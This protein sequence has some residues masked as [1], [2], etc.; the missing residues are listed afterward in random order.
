MLRALAGVLL[1]SSAFGLSVASAQL[2]VAMRVNSTDV[3]VDEPFQLQITVES[4]SLQNPDVTL[5]SL[6][7]FNVLQ[8]QVS[9]PM[10]FSFSFGGRQQA[11]RSTTNYIFVLQ[12]TREGRFT[13]P[14]VEA[15]V[16]KE[17]FRSN[18][19]TITV[20]GSTA[21]PGSPLGT[22][23]PPADPSQAAPPTSTTPPKGPIADT[24]EIDDIA[25]IRAVAD[26]PNPYVGEQVT[27][28]FY[29]YLRGNVQAAPSVDTQPTTDGFWIHDLL[30]PNA[31]QQGHR[32]VVRGLSYTAFTLRRFAAFPLR[33]GPLSIGPMAVTIDQSSVFD[34]FAGRPPPVL[35]RSGQPLVIEA[36]PLPEAGKPKGEV[37]VGRFTIEAKLDRNQAATG[38]AV[39]LSATV[40]GTGNIRTV[41]LATPVVDGLRFLEPAVRDVVEAPGDLAGG[42]RTYEWLV[43]PERPGTFTLPPIVLPVFDPGA[44][45]YGAA[46]SEALTLVAAGS[47]VAPQ[48]T[49]NPAD[50]TSDTVAAPD[51]PQEDLAPIRTTSELRRR[52]SPLV[53]SLAYRVGIAA[54]ALVWL[55]VVFGA[56]ASRRWSARRNAPDADRSFREAG[57]KLEAAS[58]EAAAARVYSMVSSA[59]TEAVQARLHE[60]IGGYTGERLRVVL[61]ARGMDASLAQDLVALLSACE[62]GRFSPVETSRV[63][64]DEL[65]GVA[66]KCF[67]ALRSFS[68]TTEEA[69]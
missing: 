47:A 45:Q 20:R 2:T 43:V 29:L 36:K 23:T 59:I 67:D 48:A 10:S 22:T 19:L 46:K 5:P 69:S 33:E 58:H 50:T 54:P 21:P 24:A 9:R 35:K 66:R 1:L 57:R 41:T 6:D 49:A 64:R 37:A 25:F 61:R 34:L 12:P 44:A 39:T 53:E 32:Q 40:Q 51:E 30:S 27:V 52:E 14:A 3:R 16:G 11:A 26:K 28:T 68:P 55:L 8:R 31:Q 17:V 15:R 56:A 4:E 13:L 7:E 65:L 60:P 38:D 42:I 62:Q 63:Q 18:A